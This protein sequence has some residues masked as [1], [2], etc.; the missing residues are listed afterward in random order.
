[1]MQK[2]WRRDFETLVLALRRGSDS[3]GMMKFA[4]VESKLSNCARLMSEGSMTNKLLANYLILILICSW[5]KPIAT[6]LIRL[7]IRNYSTI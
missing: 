4:S 7:T 5:G 2:I 6:A 1:M 3:K